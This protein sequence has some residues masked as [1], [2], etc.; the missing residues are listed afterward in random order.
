MTDFW[1]GLVGTTTKRK[2]SPPTTPDVQRRYTEDVED[3]PSTMIVAPLRSTMKNRK[4]K[5]TASGNFISSSESDSQVGNS[6]PT[7]PSPALIALMQKQ[8][9]APVKAKVEETV[10]IELADIQEV[11]G[12]ILHIIQST[13]TLQG[14][15]VKF[16]TTLPAVKKANKLFNLDQNSFKLRKNII[17]PIEKSKYFE[18]MRPRQAEPEQVE[19]R[20][21]LI[22]RFCDATGTEEDVAM[23]FLSMRNW[24]LEKAVQKFEKDKHRAE[25][26]AENPAKPYKLEYPDDEEL[27]HPTVQPLSSST[28]KR[29]DK[30]DVGFFSL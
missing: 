8:K 5:Q 22:A 6:P 28:K 26:E 27:F 19:D 23:T 7:G 18:V 12:G 3:T 2:D 11:P 14:L 24:N 4:Q 20:G 9:G 30:T 16:N 15:L 1:K 21:E 13:D 25:W 17:L 29:L 10:S